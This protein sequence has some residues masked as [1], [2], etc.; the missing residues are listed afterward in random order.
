MKVVVSEKFQTS[1]EEI[2]TLLENFDI[3][4]EL[5]GKGAR[6]KIKIFVFGGEKV[7]VKS[8]KIPNLVNKIAY[9]F[10]RKSKA[11][12][13]FEYAHE[14]L[15][16]GIGSPYPVA[17]AEDTSGLYFQ[18]SFYVSEHLDCD[19]T[20]RTLVQ[21]SNYPQ[22]EEILRAFTRFTFE[23]HEKQVQFLDH[24]PGNTL[25]RLNN[26]GYQFFLV[27]LNRMNFKELSFDERMKNFARLTPQ[28]KMVGVMAS[29]YAKLIEKPEAEVFAKM[30]FYTQEFQ[31]KFQ[32]KKQ[33]KKKL[34]F[35]KN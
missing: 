2:L 11:Q 22:W 34:K 21:D 17:Y 27:D 13:S 4:G 31:R 7:N 28:E 30:W 12:R 33:L 26:G 1:K 24:S 29:E 35:W 6:N 32:K 23:L 20:Y 10:I 16:R 9:R 3:K 8:F 19:L 15:Q 18:K 14:L 5:V 25:I